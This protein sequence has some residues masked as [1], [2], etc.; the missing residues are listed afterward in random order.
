MRALRLTILLLDTGV[1][2]PKKRRYS[3]WGAPKIK[4]SRRSES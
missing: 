2:K 1:E 4:Y 3:I